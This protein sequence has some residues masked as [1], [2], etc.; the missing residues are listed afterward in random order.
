MNGAPLTIE[1]P[2]CG[3][4][5]VLP[6]LHCARCGARLDTTAD[7]ALHAAD[8]RPR[9]RFRLASLLR[10]LALLAVLAALALLLWPVRLE[11]SPAAAVDARRY[12]V[13]RAM[14]DDAIASG[15]PASV[16]IRDADFNAFL[17]RNATDASSGSAWR[18][19]YEGAAVAFSPASAVATLAMSR[20]PFRFTLQL[21]WTPDP[22][23]P[24]DAPALRLDRAR[25]GHLRLP[26]AL[27][28][29]VLDSPRSPLLAFERENAILR[30]AD[31]LELG[32]GTLLVGVDAPAAA[33]GEP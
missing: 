11:Q 3:A 10:R 23:A 9:R 24:A 8:A 28:G 15:I 6:R 5:N 32:E 26:A 4:E 21:E 7:A 12:L 30:R 14:L 2:S 25:F 16:S 18:A 29:A 20:G 27:V 19:R 33:G 17:V 1:C 13:S 22:A 31:S